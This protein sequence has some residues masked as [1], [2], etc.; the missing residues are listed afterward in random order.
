MNSCELFL[1]IKREAGD[2]V[3]EYLANEYDVQHIQSP[4]GSVQYIIQ[5]VARYNREIFSEIKKRTCV[6]V[7]EEIDADMLEDFT[8]RINQYMEDN[9]PGQTD[10]KEYIR[11]IST[12]LTFIARK[13][14]HPPGMF[15]S[16][17]QKI[18]EQ[19]NNYYC[20]AK[21]KYIVS[22]RSLCEYCVAKCLRY[23]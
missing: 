10:F 2:M 20:P 13:P 9:A 8:L 5:S 6:N 15:I 22:D 17:N 7:S 18:I 19:D 12:Y 23:V 1:T 3:S 21:S 14:L 16:D 11:I 4:P